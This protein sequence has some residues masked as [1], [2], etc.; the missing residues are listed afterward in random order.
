MPR[1]EYAQRLARHK[2]RADLQARRFDRIADARLV[3]FIA[4]LVLAGSAYMSWLSWWFLA[5]PILAFVTLV[6]WHGLAAGERDRA[7]RATG[8]Y[9]S[10]LARLDG[11]WVG[12][13]EPGTR[14][15]DEN[16]PYAADLDLFGPGSVF[17]RL[18]TARTPTGQATLAAWLLAPAS[19]DEVLARQVAV[20]ELRPGLDLREELALL[21]DEVKAGVH[22][23][24]LAAWGAAP[25]KPVSMT[26]RRVADALAVLALLT[27]IGW[28]F[29]GTG[30]LPFAVLC[31]VNA[32]LAWWWRPRV[33]QIV[34][35]IERQ[36][37]ELD[38]LA[39]LL[40]RIEQEPFQAPR[41]LKVRD[42]LLGE[43]V[44]PSQRIRRLAKL[45]GRLEVKENQLVLPIAALMLWTTRTAFAIEA[46]RSAEGPSI[47]QWL[48]AAGE[49]E[50]LNALAAYAYENPD[51]PFP[52]LVTDQTI[53][54]GEGLGHPLIAPDQ[55]V[56]NNVAL[57]GDLRVLVI[58]GSNM[59]GKSTLLR[60]VGVNVV[61][62]LAGAP[63][64]AHSMRVSPVMIGATLRVQDSLQA[65]RSRFY[66]EITRVRQLVDL[67]RKAPPLL[68]L[69]DEVFNGTNS[70]DRRQG[71]EAVVRSLVDLGALGLVTTHDLALADIAD[72]L[73]PRAANVHF[74]DRLEDGLMIFDYTM[75][76]GVVQH[77]NALALMR[78]VGLEV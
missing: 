70:H 43:G 67:A 35:T 73:G 37:S 17:E 65:G 18:C 9:E 52:T 13:G 24:A 16:H 75:R 19:A 34:A 64:R 47:R 3:V 25:P 27:L 10:A 72:R 56:R 41:L 68:F 54:E 12:N 33:H 42:A 8:Y 11:Q 39:D 74:E 44:P 58:S 30:P 55:L 71:A 38:L 2:T 23:D 36:A 50:A 46:W 40:T 78:A 31:L 62:A 66:A 1:D 60:T 48:T 15:L 28:F 77:S 45:A 22:P 20:E 14:F 26:V 21:G 6:F 76:P 69:L 61:L 4:A 49:V 53:V 5:A 29:V 63:V 7:N 59:S 32:G 57:S 51:D